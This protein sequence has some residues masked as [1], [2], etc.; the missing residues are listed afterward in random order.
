MTTTGGAPDERGPR[1]QADGRLVPDPRPGD[2]D[3]RE[4]KDPMTSRFLTCLT[5][6]RQAVRNT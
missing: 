6:G 2:W 5:A 3:M 4:M 1:R